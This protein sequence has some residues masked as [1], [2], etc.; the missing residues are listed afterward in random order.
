MAYS[1]PVYCAL[2]TVLA[3]TL[4]ASPNRANLPPGHHGQALGLCAREEVFCEKYP[5]QKM[6]VSLLRGWR[7]PCRSPGLTSA[8]RIFSCVF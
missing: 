8:K 4:H 7:V 1:H 6:L 5:G 2:A 3:G